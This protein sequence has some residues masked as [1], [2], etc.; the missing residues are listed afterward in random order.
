MEDILDEP[1][2]GN[3]RNSYYIKLIAMH[4][5]FTLL[6]LIFLM[7][8]VTFGPQLLRDIVS[9]KSYIVGI[10][11]FM[12]LIFNSFVIATKLHLKCSNLS[13]NKIAFAGGFSFFISYVLFYIIQNVF[14]HFFGVSGYEILHIVFHSFSFSLFGFQFGLIK[15]KRIRKQKRYIE[16][17]ILVILFLIFWFIIS[18]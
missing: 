5:I 15:S 16:Y 1:E 12:G 17:F 14:F 11:I 7:S 9:D 3:Y 2:N 8:I 4:S 13:N 10:F 6:Y 18:N